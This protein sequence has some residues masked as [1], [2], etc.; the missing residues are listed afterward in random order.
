MLTWTCHVS[1]IETNRG[2]SVF[3]GSLTYCWWTQMTTTVWPSRTSASLI[4][5]G[6]SS[7]THRRQWWWHLWGQPWPQYMLTQASRSV[8][9]VLL[10]LCTAS[11][12]P[13]HL[14]QDLY[15]PI[16]PCQPSWLNPRWYTLPLKLN[17]RSSEHRSTFSR[18]YSERSSTKLTISVD[19]SAHP[20][21]HGTLRWL[22]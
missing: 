11:W 12:F 8:E 5:C 17:L 4:F 9:V 10:L 15:H 16:L 13:Q 22:S 6:V 18:Q 3:S 19:Y 21:M 7:S 1:Q 14:N 2:L 20:A